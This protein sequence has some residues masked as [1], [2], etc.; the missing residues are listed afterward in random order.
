MDPRLGKLWQERQHHARLV[1]SSAADLEGIG[2]LTR[3]EIKHLIDRYAAWLLINTTETE[4][5]SMTDRNAH[6]AATK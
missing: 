6:E 5:I 1:I 4:H 3:L 2:E